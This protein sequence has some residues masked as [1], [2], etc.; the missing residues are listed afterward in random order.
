MIKLTKQAHD[1]FLNGWK[2]LG[3]SP[4]RQ[5]V[6]ILFESLIFQLAKTTYLSSM[7]SAAI[8]LLERCIVILD[9]VILKLGFHKSQQMNNFEA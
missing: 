8:Y 4:V 3:S 7:I 5:H 1:S 6:S 9:R 2:L